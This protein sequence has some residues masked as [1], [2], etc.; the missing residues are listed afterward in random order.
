MPIDACWMLREISC[1]AAP[2]PS[3]AA[4]MADEISDSFSMVPEISQM[5]RTD[6]CVAA[7]MLPICWPISPVALAVCS[8]GAFTSEA[9]A[10]KP[11][12]ASPDRIRR[13]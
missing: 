13:G 6:S 10:A 12:P 9:T 1:V 11:R 8:A 5:A 2:C 4:A 3:T 7:W